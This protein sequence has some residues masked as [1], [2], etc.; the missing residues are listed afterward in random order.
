MNDVVRQLKPRSSLDPRVRPVQRVNLT[1]AIRAVILALPEGFTEGDIFQRIACLSYGDDIRMTLP[2]GNR[3]K[4]GNIV[5]ERGPQLY[6]CPGPEFLARIGEA[7]VLRS[8]RATLPDTRLA[9]LRKLPSGSLKGVTSPHN[10]EDATEYWAQ[11]YQLVAGQR[12]WKRPTTPPPP[13]SPAPRN[14]ITSHHIA[15]RIRSSPFIN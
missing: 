13:P 15:F 2:A 3:N 7:I 11:D 14:C 5:R 8:C 12:R 9:H 4:V 10:T 1:Y 6:Y